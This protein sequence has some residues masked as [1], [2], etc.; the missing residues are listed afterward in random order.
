[1][2]PVGGTRPFLYLEPVY[3]GRPDNRPP[4]EVTCHF[5]RGVLALP[6]QIEDFVLLVLRPDIS[7]ETSVRL[8]RFIAIIKGSAI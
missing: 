8:N 4:P 7:G 6:L 5:G 3:R 1:V 2:P